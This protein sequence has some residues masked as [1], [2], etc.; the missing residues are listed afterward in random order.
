MDTQA[1]HEVAL[2]HLQHNEWA[3]A[4]ECAERVLHEN[5][6]N[7]VMWHGL[8][9]ALWK[10][11]KPNEAI[12]PLKQALQKA[13]TLL[14]ARTLG[15]V[16]KHIGLWRESVLALELAAI[17]ETENEWE[18]GSGRALQDLAATR[19]NLQ[20]PDGAFCKEFL[21]AHNL[22]VSE[23]LHE[24]GVLR[25]ALGLNKGAVSVFEELLRTEPDNVS[26]LC[27]SASCYT[28]LEEENRADE[29]LDRALL[30]APDS[31]EANFSKGLLSAKNGK[32]REAR[33]YLE[34][35]EEIEPE[36]EDVQ[37]YLEQI[38]ILIPLTT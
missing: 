4:I 35:A 5:P 20:P 8:G 21:K 13:I 36:A 15:H 24:I 27:K 29:Y 16:Y 22:N 14:P 2:T 33:S 10:L 38:N 18:E 1:L 17:A 37:L 11:G 6:D 19:L 9:L 28:A 23:Y 25:C 3:L 26:A 32:L 31:F 30:I 12:E 34:K 7:A